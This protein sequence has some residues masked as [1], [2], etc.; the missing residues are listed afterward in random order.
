MDNYRSLLA[1][2]VYITSDV[3]GTRAVLCREIESPP[4]GAGWQLGILVD[5]NDFPFKVTHAIWVAPKRVLVFYADKE[6]VYWDQGPKEME[7]A[8][9]RQVFFDAFVQG[10]LEDGWKR[11]EPV[12]L[13]GDGMEI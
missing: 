8:A 7:K 9:A 10:M 5:F 6:I 4:A 11:G 2:S 3:Q 13:L 1:V 12:L